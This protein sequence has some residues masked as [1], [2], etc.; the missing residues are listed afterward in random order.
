MH[1]TAV[2]IAIR[3]LNS[4][5]VP[6]SAPQ[7]YGVVRN[8]HGEQVAVL[9]FENMVEV[10]AGVYELDAYDVSDAVLFPGTEFTIFWC[11]K[12]DVISPE[13]ALQ[14]YTIYANHPTG[15]TTRLISWCPSYRPAKLYGYRIT[16]KLRDEEEFTFLANT[17]YPYY[18]DRTEYDT[19]A[20]F[21]LASFLV[22]EL[23]WHD[24]TIDEPSLGDQVFVVSFTESRHEYCEVYGE[25]I[26][27]S[28][29]AS[30]NTVNFFVHEID[31]P[32]DS[33]TALFM[34]RHEITAPVNYRG[35]F[36][37]PLI[38]GALVTAE[39][40]EAG[41]NR[42]FVVP[43]TPHALMKDLTFYPLETHRA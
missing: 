8:A 37:A 17:V 12:S 22:F 24:G 7:L 40:A 9:T 5:G 13:T 6:A 19:P 39:I 26:D 10:T 21:H 20:D 33:G 16:R 35:E 15:V 4:A 41:I 27:V 11:T 34:K 2:D 18:F 28:G 42:R 14:R 43:N 23:V 3:T 1:I 32:Q 31:T 30:A 25:V 36:S 38:R 29:G